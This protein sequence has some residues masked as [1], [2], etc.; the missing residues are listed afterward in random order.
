MKTKTMKFYEI[1]QQK[2]CYRRIIYAD[3]EQNQ[4]DMEFGI[5][6]RK[7]T[8]NIGQTEITRTGSSI[9]IISTRKA[10]QHGEVKVTFSES[11]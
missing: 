1:D 10:H 3:G 5:T 4:R 9:S 7:M 8:E 11:H 6:R 2:F